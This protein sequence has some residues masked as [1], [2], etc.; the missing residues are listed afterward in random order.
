RAERAGS[1][2]EKAATFAEIGRI[3]LRD[4]DDKE[5]ALVAFTHAFAEDPG[6]AEWSNEIQRLAG[7]NLERWQEVLDRLGDAAQNPELSPD[8]RVLLQ[9]R[10]GK[11]W[12]ER[13]QRPDLALPL[14]QA[15]LAVEPAED[16]ALAGLAQIYRK[17]QQWNE[18]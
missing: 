16:T 7:A 13:A 15:V 14:F 4:L 5:Q 1:G 9:K 17:A 8:P 12:M 6:R 11:W 3:Y 18:L 2:S 10:V